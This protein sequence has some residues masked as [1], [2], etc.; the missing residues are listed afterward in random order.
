MVKTAHTPIYQWLVVGLGMLGVVGA[1]VL[2]TRESES[3]LYA[4]LLVLAIA[5]LAFALTGTR[6]ESDSPAIV[7]KGQRDGQ[8]PPR[9]SPAPLWLL[10]LALVMIVVTA[11]ASDNLLDQTATNRAVAIRWL[12]GLM[13]LLVF[14]WW[15]PLADIIQSLRR[16][17]RV[18]V[19]SFRAWGP[20]VGIIAVAAI[21]RF[22]ML[23][24]Y[25]T[26]IGGDEGNH[27]LTARASQDGSL[28]NPFGTGFFSTPNL[29][30]VVDGF[31]ADL[32]GSDVAAYRTWTAL[33]GAAGVVATWRLGR[34]LV[35]PRPAMIGAIIL[36]TMPLHLFFSRTAFNNITDP[37]T[38]VL[39]ILFLLRSLNSAE[40]GNA[41][42]CGVVLGC[43]FYGYYG[44]RAIP[45]VVLVLLGI[46]AMD[47][48][49]GFGNAFRLGGWMVTGFLATAMPL[50][51]YYINN[52]AL[53]AGH[54][55]QVS[56]IS[57]DGLRSD[58]GTV[59]PLYLDNLFDALM[60]PWVGNDYFFFRH[61]A[62]FLRWPVAILIA[63]GVAVWIDRVIRSRDI[64]TIACLVTP[65]LMLAAGVALTTPV[66]AHRLMALTPFWALAAGS[67][68]FVVARWLAAA[69]RPMARPIAATVIVVALLAL[70]ISELRWSASEE[71][72]RT[73]VD[74]RTILA[75]DLGWR[76]SRHDPAWETMPA[77]LLAGPPMMF[78][79]G[80]G[81]LRFLAPDL[82]ISD[83]NEPLTDASTAPPLPPDTVLV[84]IG[85]RAGERC[86]VEQIYPD[87]TMAEIRAWDG[88]L[89][90]IA[91]FQEPLSGW[92]TATTPAET[93]YEV[94]TE[95]GCGA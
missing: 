38:I 68:L 45:I 11:G 51:V 75:W 71:R 20:W 18:T 62:P 57:L 93:T 17:P 26:V 25:P 88:A 42:T 74:Y 15:H 89:L 10:I 92:S 85:E 31:V 56:A 28:P 81:N 47:R 79:N 19:P 76:L 39:A 36:A 30:L 9:E 13:L 87:A 86:A 37:T 82:T 64:S 6:G 52:P 67:G 50:I 48:R 59:I 70:S 54:L 16:R 65:W 80:W 8:A 3:W 12:L 49:I 27:M 29:Y 95:S 60:L 41:I 66:G 72:Q 58:P 4:G 14:A 84:L 61:E 53:F 35:G 23:N 32:L 40:R 91:Y 2:V 33:V 46:V 1:V 77:V 83:V 24:R 69:W 94:V 90:Y 22:V 55:N 78:G 34:Y 5:V 44:G 21:P 7:S 73:Y 63:L 43:G